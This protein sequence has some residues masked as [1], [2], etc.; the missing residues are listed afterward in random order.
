M[1][2]QQLRYIVA[3]AEYG[4]ITRAAQTLHMGQPALT[5]AIRAL[6]RELGAELFERTSRGLVLTDAGRVLVAGATRALDELGDAVERVRALGTDDQLVLRLVARPAAARDPGVALV[7]R[8]RGARPDVLV[9]VD[10]V[11]SVDEATDLLFAD[12]ADLALTDPVGAV[13]GLV[14]CDVGVHRFVALLPPGAQVPDPIGWDALARFPMIG[15]ARSDRRWRAVDAAFV[16]AGA[17]AEVVVEV[18]RRELVLPLVAAGVGACIG[19][20]F[21]RDE[22]ERLGITC[23]SLEP[24]RSRPVTLVRQQRALAPHVEECWALITGGDGG[25]SPF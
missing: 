23:A 14:S 16:G 24:E 21:Q 8:I 17:A 10:L 22:A 2:L 15:T 25:P 3:V 19:Y 1:N 7:A 9:R 6:E 4:T 5:Q 20:E 11:E 12:G 18:N 13:A